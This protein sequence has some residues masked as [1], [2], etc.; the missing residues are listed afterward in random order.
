MNIDSWCLVKKELRIHGFNES[1]ILSI[2]TAISV[3]ANK[4]GVKFLKL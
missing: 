2:Y 1:Q 3:V 4:K